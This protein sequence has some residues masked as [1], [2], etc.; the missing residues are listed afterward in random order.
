MIDGT[1]NHSLEADCLLEHIFFAGLYFGQFLIKEFFKILF[2]VLGAATTFFNSF[3]ACFMI[4]NGVKN[5]FDTD[6]LMSSFFSFPD[7]KPESCG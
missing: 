4:D 2:D 1:L 7:G 6:I 3:K 5:M